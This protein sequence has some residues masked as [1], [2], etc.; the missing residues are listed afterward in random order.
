MSAE[1]RNKNIAL[2]LNLNSENSIVLT[3][4][5]ELEQVFFNLVSNAMQAIEDR[6]DNQGFITVTTQQNTHEIIIDI[7]DTGLGVAKELQA[8][9]FDPFVTGRTD[10][11]GLGLALSSRL[12]ERM[13]GEIILLH[14]NETGACFR[15]TLPHF[16]D[17]VNS[18]VSA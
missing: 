13:N 9:L 11:T 17:T 3:D 14:S 6:N 1:L 15:I 10:G 16:S 2:K 18:R 4:P 7:T 5:V 8:T 12:I